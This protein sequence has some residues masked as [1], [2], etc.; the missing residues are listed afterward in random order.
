MF[1]IR[2]EQ[3]GAGVNPL[4]DGSVELG[5]QDPNSGIAVII[6]LDRQGKENLIRMLEGKPPTGRIVVPDVP[7]NGVISTP[8]NRQQRRHPGGLA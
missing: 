2:L 8:P 4:E 3:V 6:P 7:L 5:F 1:I